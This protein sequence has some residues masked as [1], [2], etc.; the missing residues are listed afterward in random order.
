LGHRSDGI[1]DLT[2]SGDAAPRLGL[3]LILDSLE[4]APPD[5]AAFDQTGDDGLTLT[6]RAH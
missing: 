1:A 6:K 5:T 4:G 3:D 2:R